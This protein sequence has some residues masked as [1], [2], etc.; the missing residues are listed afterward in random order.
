LPRETMNAAWWNTLRYTFRFS[1][2]GLAWY[3]VGQGAGP[4]GGLPRTV[5]RDPSWC[6]SAWA[7]C[8]R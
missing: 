3:R 8:A 4:A 7:S 6:N 5:E 1:T 2:D